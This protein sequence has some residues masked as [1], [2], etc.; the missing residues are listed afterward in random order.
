MDYAKQID[1]RSFLRLGAGLAAGLP[2]AGCDSELLTGLPVDRTVE[3][4]RARLRDL[5]IVIGDL[6]PGG[7]NAITDVEG[8]RVGHV[9][10]I[11][12]EGKLVIGEGPVRTGV[13]AV[14]PHGGDITREQLFAADFDLNGNGEMT[15]VGQIRRS[16]RL[17][18]P[19]LLTNTSSVG[20]VYDGAMRYMMEMNPEFLDRRPHPEPVV[21][22][23][24]ADF[25]NDTAGRHVRPEHAVEALSRASGGAVAEGC[26]GG[27]TGMRAFRF[28]AGIGT[29]S[30]LIDCAE[31]VYT[32]GVLVQAN[33][34]GREQLRVDGV[35]IGREIADLM[36]ERGKD[37]GGNSLL[38]VIATDAPLIPIQLRR[39]CKRASLGMA[40]TG[41]ISTHGS[42]DLVVA[43]STGTKLAGKREE[44]LELL[45]D[46]Y[47]SRVHQGVVEGT[48]EAILNSLTAADTM[49]GRDGNRIH[50]LPLDR[51]VATMQKYGRLK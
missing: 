29:A 39:L 36:P 12:E 13:T 14:L 28:K 40:R 33:F 31:E 38:V 22:E 8:V 30:R 47:I 17:G 7:N 25:L 46:R 43:F 6:I 26:V 41:G 11:H 5:G 23:T 20:A 34:G 42:G 35:P 32:V 48:E 3:G 16:G 18:A 27:G 9:T 21:G 44:A 50:A 1:R 15:G 24:W 45:S 10:L 37:E 4:R 49:V 51:L 2:L 19:I